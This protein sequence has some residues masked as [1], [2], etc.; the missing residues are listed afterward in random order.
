MK[1]II[2]TFIAL[3]SL[4]ALVGCVG[5]EVTVSFEENGGEAIADIA[6]VQETKMNE[7]LVIREGYTFEGWYEEIGL[8]TLF[9]FDSNILRNISL[10]AKWSIN[11]YTVTFVFDNGTD[12]IVIS[13]TYSSTITFPTDPERTGY[14]FGGWYLEAEGTTEFTSNRIPSADTTV[15]TY[16]IQ[17]QHTVNFYID[18]NAETPT[19]TETVL[20]GESV[21][22][23][24]AIPVITGMNGAW[25]EDITNIT[26][27]K[28]VTVEY[29][30]KVFNITFQDVEENTYSTL[31]LE[32]GDSI[33]AP[34]TPVKVG[35]DL[36]G[37]YSPLLERNIDFT[38]Y[39]V[40]EDLVLVDSFQILT[41]SVKFFGGEANAL[42]GSVEFI[43]YGSSAQAPTEGIDRDGYTFS[44]WDSAFDTV[45]SDLNV[46][47]E[48]TI[49]QYTAVFDANGGVYSDATEFI[50][51]TQ[52]YNSNVTVSEEP[53]REGFRFVGWYLDLNYEEEV[54]F[55][56]G[57]TMSIDGFTVYA[58]WFDL[59][60]TSY[61]VSGTY[62]FE[63]EGIASDELSTDGSYVQISSESYT[64][65]IKVFYNTEMSP[66][67]EIDG[68]EFYKYVYNGQDCFDENELLTIT[69]DETVDVY[70]RRIILSVSFSEYISEDI[71]IYY[72]YY[73]GSLTNIPTATSVNGYDFISYYAPSLERNV[74]LT[75]YIITENLVL[76][77][78]FRIQTYSVTFFGGETDT[79]L[80]DV[81]TID[82][83]TSAL[84]PT[85]GLERVGYTF[86]GWDQVFDT[87]TGDIDV[88]AEYTINQYTAS[89][90]ANGGVY[91][92]ASGIIN[93]T[94]DY[95]STVNNP[96]DP[97]RQDF[98]FLGWYYDLNY[99]EEA[100]FSKGKLLPING[101]TV[102]AK[103]FDLAT[104]NYTVSGTTYL[105]QVGIASDELSTD[106][107]YVQ[108]SSEVYIPYIN[109]L[110]KNEMV[111][112]RD[113]EGY[114]FYK[115]VYNGVDYF[116][117]SQLI[118]ITKDETV[119]VYYRKIVLTVSFSE[120]IEEQNVTTN[121]YVY[122]N[123]S[124]NS[125]PTATSI[126]GYEFIGYYAPLLETY[127]DLTTYTVTEDV[128]MVYNFQILTFN[129]T[130]YGGE[131][132][133]Q[134]G[135]VQ[136]ID[137]GTA[138][139]A[140]TAGLDRV[141]YTFSDWDI[142]FDTITTDLIVTA[143]Y[144]INQYI[145]TFNANSGVYADTTGIIA[146]TQDFNSNVTVPEE[147]TKA[148]FRFVGWYTDLNFEEEVNFSSGISLPVN[149]FTVYAKWLDLAT[150]TYTI[151][152]TTYLEEEGIASDG[153]STNETY[154][155]TN[156]ESYNPFINVVYNTQMSPVRDIDGYEFYKYAYNGVDY[157]DESQ[158]IT[159]TQDETVDVYY[160]RIVL[161]VS[162][163]EF[164][165]EDVTTYYVYCNDF[166]TNIP[167][168][169][170]VTGYD[171]IGY[172][173]SLLERNIDFTTYTITEDLVMVENFQILT[174]NVTFYGGETGA[175][176]GAVQTIDYGTSALAPT[177]GLERVG[178]TFTDWDTAFDSITNSIDVH[179][180][181]SINQYTASFNANGGAYSDTTGIISVTQ[182]YNSDVFVPEEPTREDFVFLGWYYDLT[183]E[184]EANFS[185]SIPMSID[186][187]TVYA[188]WFDL[189]TTSY[190]VSGT[191]YLEQVG[192]ASDELSTDG[193]YVQTSSEVYTPYINVLYKNEMVPV[194]DIDG[195]EF[196]KYVYN[197]VDYYDE[198][199]L[200]TITQNET[201]D[202]YYRKIVLSISFSEFISGDIS[203]YYVYCNGSLTNIPTATLVT[204]YDFIGYYSPLLETYID[205]T[206]YT[207]TEDLVLEENFQILT[208]SVT[209]YGGDTAAQLGDVQIIDYGTAALAPTAGLDRDGYTFSDWDIVFDSVTSNIDVHA[210]YTINQYTA[211]FDANSGVYIDTT[212]IMTVTQEFNS[213]VTVPEVPTKNGFIFEGWYTD[214]N[215]DVE[216]YFGTGIPMSV[217][218]FTVYA[219]WAELV[220]TRYTVEGTYYFEEETIA[221][222]QLS[223]DGTFVQTNSE[224]YTPFINVLYD[225]D[226]S[227]VRD[228][229]GYEF[230]K[231]VYNGVEY[232]D[233]SQLITITQN[234]TVDVYYR[235]IVLSVSFS[236]QLS[237]GNVTKQYYVY[238]N[239]NLLTVP[240]PTPVTGKTVFWERQNFD[241]IKT[242]LSILVI[243]YDDTLKTVI[244]MSNG[245]IIYIATNEEDLYG[246]IDPQANVLTASS[247]L[248]DIQQNGYRF[249]G[250]FISGTDTLVAVGDLYYDNA[251][252]D[253]ANITTIEARW[254]ALSE[255]NTASDV[256]IV[257]DTLNKTITIDFTVLPN[258]VNG[259]EVYPTD[260][261]FILNGEYIRSS[262]VSG[263]VLKNY[264]TQSGN[265]F[266]LTLTESD[267]Y[268]NFFKE[269]LM[270]A[271][272]SYQTLIPGTHTLQIISVG[273]NYD[274]MSSDPSDVYQY[275]VESIYENIPES[276]TITDYYIIEDFGG[277]T[278]R[279]IF[280]SNLTYQF[281]GMTF[282][283][284]TGSNHITADSNKLITTD[285][286]GEFRF[287]ITDDSG[288]R[289]YDGLVIKD[290]RQFDI[291]TSYQNYLMQVNATTDDDLFLANTT[292]NSYYVG[293]N[294]GFYLDVLIRDNN[295]AKISL[296]DALITYEFY[297]NGSATPLDETN[298]SDYVSL[299]GNVMDFTNAAV[300]A[301][302]RIV[303]EPKYEATLMNMD[304]LEYNILVNDG[305]NAFTNADLKALYA[306]LNVNQINVQRN[307]EAELYSNQVYSDGSPI[308]EKADPGNDYTN[309]GNVYFR[310]NG[311]TDDD[312]ITL[313]GNFMTIDGSDINCINS[314]MDGYGNIIYAQGFDIVSTQIG[315]FYY[316]VYQTSPD[317]LIPVTVN[318]NQFTMN[319]LK[320]V[321]N[322]TTPSVNYGGTEEEIINQE[323]LMSQNSG[324]MLG[325]V[326]RNGK[327]S[328]NNLILG[329]TLIGVTTNAYGESTDHDVLTVDLDYVTIYD[330]WA[331]SIYSH[332]GSGASITNSSIGSSGGAAIHFEDTHPGAEVY[333]NP[334]L[335]L[336]EG[337]DINNWISGQESWFKAYAMSSIALGLKSSING[338]V[339]DLGKTVIDMVENPVTGLNTEMMNLVFLSLPMTGA[340][341][342]DSS[343]NVTGASEVVLSITD[344]TGTT[345]LERP[346]NFANFDPRVSGGQ[347]GFALGS[348]SD[349]NEFITMITDI[350]TMSG[351]TVDQG[352]AGQL[353]AIAGFYNLSAPEILGVAQ[354]M[355]GGSGIQ[356]SVIA[357]KGSL[358]YAQPQYIEVIAPLELTGADGSATI[359]IE[360]LNL[361]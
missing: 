52:D 21:A 3:L 104:T 310:I 17:N 90:D 6:V 143:E 65:F 306:N 234:E 213:N 315:I 327:A 262:D 224:V 357:V 171:F 35:Y 182:N 44:G 201:V 324:G 29:T 318:N 173:S 319:N 82:Y 358:D 41:F 1:K 34:T 193:S 158:L 26:S 187:F 242:N 323:R 123:G 307:I 115:Y 114:E 312:Q 288:S 121:Y 190:T 175:Q 125:V 194:R 361:E 166:L 49:N 144:S 279:Y 142:A 208:F 14:I 39:T 301:E 341:T 161:S 141:G 353:A 75:T 84:A 259:V 185:T 145:A 117:E 283:I 343:G 282:D 69:Q 66:V 101:F 184:Q 53:T 134:L 149:G 126:T 328:L 20:Y 97:T 87:V 165:S 119:D 305:Y 322:T 303:I 359:L 223:V 205:L 180:E 57:V 76:E 12:D 329:Y 197:G 64:P 156:S 268:Y 228:I 221:I 55:A 81:Q 152:G 37:Y 127:I 77:E 231:Y 159:I 153:L 163:T 354:V 54:Y 211:S 93:V 32:Y 23:A 326:I 25:S 241:N 258:D 294:N 116:D 148:D 150:T 340:V 345:L 214:L 316:D 230:Y 271:E 85:A 147:P 15:Y 60:T 177:A 299:V 19:Y 107:S 311:N 198:N 169:M 253:A 339:G 28:D 293:A 289:T 240:T 139:L 356:D 330:S 30:K 202:V 252:F 215:Y 280:Y 24:P 296:D 235:R 300:G 92:D 11:S 50:N 269:N 355:A 200:I 216:I 188:K 10:Y 133:A 62:Y 272:D 321:G 63:E 61:T 176:L 209:F 74:D 174:F 128:A 274:V 237:E 108:T 154:V 291:G 281:A 203:T 260:Y 227:P 186:G 331:N 100:Y 266:T 48:Y 189:A 352:T 195:Y 245:T 146:V 67:R 192:I 320:V 172:Y 96:E 309:F 249:L 286:P 317:P 46:Y 196:Y 168:P 157:T 314:E 276:S 206:T 83:G 47:A 207:V 38:N 256:S 111:P 332:G 36:I 51:V 70:Y 129:V 220:A 263:D 191:Y 132:G 110:Y 151:S 164:I 8:S 94:Q 297:M 88:Y 106:G 59:S 204:G 73:N 212:G 219:K 155:Q 16:W 313:E 22:N 68:Y 105:E 99:E 350:M 183:F 225:T 138:A 181:Y 229:E 250:W 58:K 210:E 304:A 348:L 167:T 102:Y 236:E 137:Y 42:L 257:A 131:T 71:T 233:E 295:G 336:G 86:T 284:E 338:A 113:I 179:A 302:F 7:P 275:T 9:D 40:T 267:P 278:L 290:I 109:V 136:T 277:G 122:Y 72:V 244:F 298:L 56:T 45:T 325:V 248:W 130:F 333:D 308:N 5:Q 254:V 246:V 31:T 4:T 238:Y 98:V 80:G 13:D 218:G 349:T 292:D 199:Q 270:S 79:Q 346:W 78:N 335:I 273:D 239:E 103:W 265:D 342:K 337:N 243:Q 118:T 27:D 264:I 33:T 247:P 2:F 334:A 140:P 251:Y 226:M 135:D 360:M 261:T 43:D 222:D 124:L 217:D 351:G 344:P 347:Y 170:L 112:I 18:S 89:F 287:T 285:I 160:R 120:M 95:N 255:L 232:T 162:F 178:Y 91:S